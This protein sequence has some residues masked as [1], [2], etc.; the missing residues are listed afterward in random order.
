M[1]NAYPN[2]FIDGRE[3]P[4]LVIN[5]DHV[6][7]G[8]HDGTVHVEAGHFQLRGR[9]QGTLHLYPGSTATIVGTQAGT[10]AVESGV[11]VTVI[12]AIEGT[13][14]VERG[15]ELVVEPGAKLAGTLDNEGIV[16]IRGIFGGARSGTGEFRLEGS[17]CVKQP[18]VQDG[19]YYYDW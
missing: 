4:P 13:T 9:L 12:G 10:V 16:I 11:S 15:G 7:A 1:I 2:D 19:I 3:V 17:G 6:L 8:T 14:S 18:R 5:S